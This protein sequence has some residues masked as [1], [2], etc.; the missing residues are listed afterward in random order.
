MFKFLTVSCT[1]KCTFFRKIIISPSVQSLWP[2]T[3]ENPEKTCTRLNDSISRINFHKVSFCIKSMVL[4]K[5]H[6]CLYLSFFYIRILNSQFYTRWRRKWFHSVGYCS[7]IHRPHFYDY[8]SCRYEIIGVTTVFSGHTVFI[9]ITYVYRD[10]YRDI[11][12]TYIR[13]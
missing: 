9:C 12:G 5:S 2:H 7:F 3:A 11:Y 1:F 4:C 8:S 10:V 6:F 13:T